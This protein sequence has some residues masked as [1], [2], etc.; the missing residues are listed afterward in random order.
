M[1]Y[2]LRGLHKS[3]FSIEKYWYLDS[4]YVHR[5]KVSSQFPLILI[6]YSLLLSYESSGVNVYA[7]SKG[8]LRKTQL[9]S[10]ENK[11]RN[12]LIQILKKITNF[13]ISTSKINFI[14]G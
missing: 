14:V 12:I 1:C 9:A 13:C 11:F 6:M 5:N 7:F 2:F 3:K 8:K 4:K 10:I